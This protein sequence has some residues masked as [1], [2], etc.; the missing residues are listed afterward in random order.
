MTGPS[1][2][3]R[4]GRRAA[5][6]FISFA[7]IATFTGASGLTALAA[8]AA[9]LLQRATEGACKISGKITGIGCPLAGTSVTARHGETI[10]GAT[11]SGLD[12]AYH[13]SLPPDTYHLTIE[14][15]GFQRVER[16]VTLSA[17][18]SGTPCTQTVDVAMTLRPR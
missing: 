7:G 10:Q 13:L 15:A 17:S 9:K 18:Q 2:R 6:A 4:A 8:P 14:M 16:D 12:G 3:L 11:S 5:T 1:T